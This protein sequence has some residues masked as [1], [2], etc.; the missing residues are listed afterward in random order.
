M[1]QAAAGGSFAA[2]LVFFSPAFDAAPLAH[3]LLREVPVPEQLGCSTAGEIGPFGPMDG[4]AVALLFPADAFHCVSGLV[5]EISRHGFERGAA[6]ASAL[7]DRLGR[8]AGRELEGSAFALTLIDGL[9]NREEVMVSAFHAGLRNLPHVGG[10]AGDGLAFRETW[11]IHN[12]TA[13]RDAALLCLFSTQVPFRI[14]KSDHYQPTDVRLVVTECDAEHRIVTEMNGATAT[15]EYAE[16]VGLNPASLSPMS[17]ASHPLVVKIGDDYF[18]RSI[19]RVEDKGLSFFCAID[20]GVVLTLARSYDMAD[21]VDRTLGRLDAELGGLDI[22]LGF[23]C[24]LRRVEAES[25]QLTLRVA[26]RYRHYNVVG[27]H[28]YGEQYNA[29]HINQ[30]FTGIAF[31]QP[32]AAVPG[33]GVGT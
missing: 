26:D 8:L 6:C 3:S 7:V 13:H 32:E 33:G 28:T 25:R 22:V 15:V 17:F 12:G 29:M 31:G 9:S 1:R 21:S 5:T 20:K 11:I 24:V 4:G 18:C 30:T 2:L 27:F 10:S 19:R 14:F 16:M 23:E